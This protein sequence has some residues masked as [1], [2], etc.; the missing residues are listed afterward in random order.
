MACKFFYTRQSCV[1]SCFV[2]FGGTSIF[3]LVVAVR[4]FTPYGPLA[5]KSILLS[6]PLLLVVSSCSGIL[7]FDKLWH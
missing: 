5:L 6:V 4:L 1:K 3:L 7:C 2:R